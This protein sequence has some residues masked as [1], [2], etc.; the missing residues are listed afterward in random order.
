MFI[1]SSSN[2]IT[3]LQHVQLAIGHYVRNLHGYSFIHDKTTWGHTNMVHNWMT[4]NGI[5]CMDDCPS[6]SPEVN[7]IESAWG[8]MN[9]YVQFRHPRSQQNSEKL[10]KEAWQRISITVIQCYIPHIHTIVQQII[11]GQ[12]WD[13]DA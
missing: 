7:A 11:N 1:Q 9:R 5:S 6:V 12:G 13:I 2:S 4:A 8:W 10:F 3:Y